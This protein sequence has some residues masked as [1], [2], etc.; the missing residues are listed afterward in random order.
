M[1]SFV[2]I[3]IVFSFLRRALGT[4]TMPP[5]QI[6]VELALFLT[7]FIMMPVFTTINDT[8]VQPYLAEEIDFNTGIKNAGIPIRN[9]MLRQIDEKDIALFLRIS[10]TPMPHTVDD[11][12]FQVIMPAFTYW[13]DAAMVVLAGLKPV[14]VDVDFSTAN[15][16]PAKIE[17]N[18]TK[19]TKV[20]FLTHLN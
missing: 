18:I 3:I 6:M 5:D 12:P 1:T 15:L 9:F 19:K 20:I 4:Q 2:R 10:K 14:F 11:L 13:A 17:K 16:D 7:I 8:A